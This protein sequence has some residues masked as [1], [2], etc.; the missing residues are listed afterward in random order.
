MIKDCVF[1]KIVQGSIPC[2]KVYE[3]DLVLAFLDI[4]P[5]TLGRRS[6]P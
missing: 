2:D 1:C 4:A 5:I 6:V 3:D